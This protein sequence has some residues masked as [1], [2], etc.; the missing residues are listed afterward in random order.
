VER[1]VANT[2]QITKQLKPLSSLNAVPE[3]AMSS[4]GYRLP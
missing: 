4:K 3:R 1:S 2:H